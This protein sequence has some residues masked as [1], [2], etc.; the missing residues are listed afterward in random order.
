MTEADERQARVKISI[1]TPTLNRANM[2]EKAIASVTGQGY[3]NVEHIIL[4]GGSTDDTLDLLSHYPHLRVIS[5][6]DRGLYDAYNKGIRNASGDVVAFLNDDD[7]YEEGIFEKVADA[8]GARVKPQI[9]SGWSSGAKETASGYEYGEVVRER[10]SERLTLKNMNL[11]AN[12]TMLNARFFDKELLR[13][14]GNFD[15]RYP[16]AADWDLMIRVA[17]HAPRSRHIPRVVH[18]Y[19]EHEHQ[20]SFGHDPEATYA[21]LQERLTILERLLASTSR[22]SPDARI[23]RRLHS[24]VVL[25]AI[26]VTRAQREPGRVAALTLQGLRHDL[27]FPLRVGGRVVARRISGRAADAQADLPEDRQAADR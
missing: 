19:R 14:V 25:T 15:I 13:E 16:V 24:S 1:V 18:R 3:P 5:E 27:L 12:E 2:I 10:P 23:L 4:D 20:V 22:R 6:P 8:F 9:V 26:G 17:M 21:G 7:F 11:D